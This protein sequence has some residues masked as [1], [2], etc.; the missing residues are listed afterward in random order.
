MAAVLVLPH[1]GALSALSRR[2]HAAVH[3]Q[4][5]IASCG[6]TE[7]YPSAKVAESLTRL[8]CPTLATNRDGAVTVRFDG[9][10]SPPRV[11]T[12]VPR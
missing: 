2:F 8:G 4:V 12:A 7:R 5:A 11:E 10:D 6:D 1:H 3:P 9:P